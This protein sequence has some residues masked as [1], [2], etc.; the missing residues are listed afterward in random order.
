MLLTPALWHL[1]PILHMELAGHSGPSDWI[2]YLV[3]LILI[4]LL[5][6]IFSG[7]PRQKLDRNR[8][9]SLAAAVKPNE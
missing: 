4:P 8:P 3:W 2:F 9:R 7:L 6:G 1:E 5:F